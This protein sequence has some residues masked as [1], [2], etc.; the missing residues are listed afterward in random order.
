[1]MDLYENWGKSQRPKLIGDDVRL[2]EEFKKDWIL[3]IHLKAEKFGLPSWFVIVSHFVF[4]F[5]DDERGNWELELYQALDDLPDDFN[6]K[7]AFHEINISLLKILEISSKREFLNVQKTK[8]LHQ[9][10]IDEGG[11]GSD[12][13]SAHL[14]KLGKDNEPFISVSCISRCPDLSSNFAQSSLCVWAVNNGKLAQRLM[15]RGLG[16]IIRSYDTYQCQELLRRGMGN[17]GKANRENR[18]G[19]IHQLGN[20]ILSSLRD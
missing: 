4:D 3:E 11:I 6:W 8:L 1:M 19:I 13:W 15:G 7:V 2:F 9:R 16:P 18:D 20:E 17:T 14:N 5:Y 10:E 12:E